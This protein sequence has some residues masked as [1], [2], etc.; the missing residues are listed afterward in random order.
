MSNAAL[1]TPAPSDR[2]EPLRHPA[3]TSKPVRH[4]FFGRWGGVSTGIH[5]G[6]N[7]GF[8][9][10]DGRDAVGRNRALAMHGLGAAPEALTTLHQIHS[11]EAVILDQPLP[12][13]QAPRADGMATDRPG[14]V[15]GILTADCA[16]VLLADPQAGVIGACHAG[17]KGALTGI[18]EATVAAMTRLG[19][20]PGSIGAVIGPCIAQPSYEVGAEFRERFLA[21][22]AGSAGFFTPEHAPGKTRF[23]LAGYVALRAG[24]AGCGTVAWT[25]QDT[26]TDPARFFSFRRATL[27][28][29]PDYGR[30][31]SAITLTPHEEH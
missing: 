19:A 3:L 24:R 23:D 30:Q 13:G 26:L 20:R 7:V 25:G 4:G 6:L 9:S 16:P 11:A 2:P 22:D 27:A 12:P 14:V 15:L 18:V 5:Q 1:P 8:G 28:G 21:E 10:D 31:L 29:E 17:W